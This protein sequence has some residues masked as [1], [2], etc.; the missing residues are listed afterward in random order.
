[1][2]RIIPALAFLALSA[3][4]ALAAEPIS[5][6][7]AE[8][9]YG[10]AAAAIGGDGVKVS[11]VIV[12]QGTDPH[13]YEPTP[14]VATSVADAGV[15]ILNGADYDPWMGRLVDASANDT[16]K[17]IDVAALIGH[18]PGDNPHVWYDP[19]AMPALAD[20]IADTL[21][22]LD[23]AGKAGYDAR[24]D[25]YL[26]SLAP[27]Q[28]KVD[29]LRAAFAGTPV[30]ATEPVFGYMAEALGFKMQNDA[31]QT[32]IM[33]ETEP[34]AAAIASMEDDIK[35][36]RVKVLFYN[37]QVEDPLTQHLSET[38]KAAGVPVV[39]VTETLPE[40][41]TFTQ[42]MLGELD[43]TAKALGAPAS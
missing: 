2:H 4:P 26:A 3:L 35:N 7:A 15:V 40:G 25:Q 23:P 34:S 20:A 21:G 18:K 8:N 10:E 17:V 27:I 12:Q 22:A 13:D 37:S 36:G 6:V 43:A 11:S 24:R 32:A 41:Q 38:A 39:G 5:I 9:F 19:K 28:Q 42:W 14:S 29:Q 31:F 30:T 1:M 16:R 33:N